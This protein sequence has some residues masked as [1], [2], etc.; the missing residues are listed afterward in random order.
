MAAADDALKIKEAADRF[1]WTVD[2]RGDLLTIRKY[3]ANR[4]EFVQA[5]GEYYSVL[6]ALPRTRSGSVWGTDGG[7]MGAIGIMDGGTFVM[8]ASG[9]SKRVLSALNKIL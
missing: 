7:G 8:N 5:D 1:G 2:V 9:G 3:V 6:S 4:E